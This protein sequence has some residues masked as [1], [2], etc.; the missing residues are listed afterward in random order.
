MAQELRLLAILVE[1]LG[2]VLG[3]HTV[4]HCGL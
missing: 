3:T 2:L 1:D 4:A